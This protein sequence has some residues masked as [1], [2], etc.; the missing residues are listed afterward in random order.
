M[1]RLTREDFESRA[2]AGDLLLRFSTLIEKGL[3]EGG[4][5]PQ[6]F[7]RIILSGGS[8]R[9]YFVEDKLRN[10][11]KDAEIVRSTLPE[12]T[13]S[14]GLALYMADPNLVLTKPVLR[15]AR[16]PIKEPST[17]FEELDKQI[18][19]EAAPPAKN[20]ALVAPARIVKPGRFEKIFKWG[21]ILWIMGLIADFFPGVGMPAIPD[22]TCG[23]STPLWLLI[24]G[25]AYYFDNQEKNRAK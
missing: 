18:A 6:S 20:V 5:S 13:I 23:C 4:L 14:K 9:W 8:S 16:S 1:V 15:P 22:L 12:Q 19:R 25:I 10:Y 24:L 3:H 7:K 17:P 2:V 21:A 11:F